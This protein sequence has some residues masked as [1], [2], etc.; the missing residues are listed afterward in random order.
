MNRTGH[1]YET[2]VDCLIDGRKTSII[3]SKSKKVQRTSSMTG[4]SIS[5]PSFDI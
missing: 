2:V 1:D 3:S 5:S 4:S